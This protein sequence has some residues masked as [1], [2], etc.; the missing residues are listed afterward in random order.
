MRNN[1]VTSSSSDSDIFRDLR[2]SPAAESH[3]PAVPP[4]TSDPTKTEYRGNPIEETYLVGKVP[5]HV[6]EMALS[7]TFYSAGSEYWERYVPASVLQIH[8]YVLRMATPG[9]SGEELTWRAPGQRQ[10]L[11]VNDDDV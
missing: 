9:G 5:R 2:T 11:I 8:S 10:V 7:E 6:Q 3:R 4:S 1:S